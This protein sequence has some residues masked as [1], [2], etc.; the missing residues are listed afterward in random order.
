MNRTKFAEEGL[1]NICENSVRVL[2]KVIFK[3]VK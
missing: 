1:I 2:V 3:K